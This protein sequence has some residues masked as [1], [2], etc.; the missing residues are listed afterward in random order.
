[1]NDFIKQVT[2]AEDYKFLKPR[3]GNR[4]VSVRNPV[5]TICEDELTNCTGGGAVSLIGDTLSTPYPCKSLQ[6]EAGQIRP[7]VECAGRP[8]WARHSRYGDE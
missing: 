6:Y 3:C 8:S 7:P 4:L 1:M 5:R 2:K